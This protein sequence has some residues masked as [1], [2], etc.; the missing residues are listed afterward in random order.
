[1]PLFKKLFGGKD[2]PK[3]ELTAHEAYALAREELTLKYPTEASSASLCCLYTSVNE[4]DM[5]IQPDGTCRGWHV[6]FF[7]PAS[8]NLCLVRVTKGKANVKEVSWEHT[9]KKPV[10]YIYAIY[11]IGAGE[12][13][14]SEPLKIPDGWLDSPAL[15]ESIRK[16]M[17]KYHDPKRELVPLALVLP[18][19]RLRYLQEV[20]AREVLSFPPTPT[21][22]FAAICGG[23]DLYD[24]D[25]Y[26]FYIESATGRVIKEHVFRFPN[27]FFFGTSVDW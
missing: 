26:L 19:E 4:A 10:E 23:E 14:S 12:A 24:E 22:C 17:E 7:L 5:E 27:L 16:A 8:R 18:A 1:M 25:S 6:D 3:K 13:V 21:Y 9:Q 2:T 20:K 15:M 11:G